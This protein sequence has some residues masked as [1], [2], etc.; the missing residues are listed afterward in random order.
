[1]LIFAAAILVPQTPLAP[2][3][4]RMPRLLLYGLILA[5]LGLSWVADWRPWP[6]VTDLWA[7]AISVIISLVA[8]VY[9]GKPRLFALCL[10]A[11]MLSYGGWRTLDQSGSGART[12]SYFGVYTVSTRADPPS[13]LLTHGTTLH[14]VQNLEPGKETEPT[15]YYGRRSGVGHALASASVWHGDNPR[16]GVV[17]LGTGTLSCYAI[18]GQDWRFYEIDPVMAG[19]AR[20]PSRFSF[21]SR[22]A[23]SARIVIGDARLSLQREPAGQMDILVV[24]AFSSD[25]VPMHLLTT[26]ALQVYRRSLKPTGLLLLHISNRYLDLE[27]VLA[28]AAKKGGW[29]AAIYSY[30]PGAE[31]KAQNVTMSVW[32][33]MAPQED[34]LMALRISSAE[35]AHLW[36]PLTERKGFPGWSDDYASIIPLLED[37]KNWVPDM[38]KP[39]K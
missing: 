11:L 6:W 33:A 1:L 17:G 30:V 20:D 16:I 27:P 12:R 14:G 22:C 28:A 32:V 38:L 29:H 2:W 23:P 4:E 18:P 10:A 5:A 15:S 7:L 31:A 19:I 21:L 8:L 36:L 25:A 39:D 9:I 35:D 34:T 3:A 13:R 37:W 26:E 24:D